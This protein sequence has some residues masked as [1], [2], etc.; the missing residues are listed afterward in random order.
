[1]PRHL[2]N[3]AHEWINEIPTVPIY[4]LA[5]PQPRERAW[6]NQRNAAMAICQLSG[7]NV[8]GRPLKCSWGK[9]R[10]P[11]GQ[12]DG[13]SPAQGPQSGFPPTPQAFFPQYGQANPM[14][15][16]GKP[17]NLNPLYATWQF[18]NHVAPFKL[19]S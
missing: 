19:C 6:R 4:Y 3:D 9:D 5:K 7:Y 8:N 16:Q 18:G 15:P 17:T 10:P 11:T 13:Y 1:M 12:F 2:I 14:S